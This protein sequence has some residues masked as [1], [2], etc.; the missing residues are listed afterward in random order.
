MKPLI[1]T[2][3]LFVSTYLH[4]QTIITES[5]EVTCSVDSIARP[6]YVPASQLALRSARRSYFEFIFTDSVPEEAKPAIKFAGR[7]WGSYLISDIPIRVEVRWFTFEGRNSLGSARPIGYIRSDSLATKTDVL[8]PLALGESLLN[9]NLNGEQADIIISINK[10]HNFYFGTDGKVPEEHYDLT[11][12]ILHEIGHGVGFTASSRI[13]EEGVGRFSK[14][15]RI[16]DTFLIARN[17]TSLTD[18]FL[19]K[20][21]SVELAAQ[22][23]SQQVYFNHPFV[24]RANGGSYVWI[25]APADFRSGS[26]ISH[27]MRSQRNTRWS[28][29]TLM[30]PSTAKQEVIH[31]PDPVALAMLSAM[32]WRVNFHGTVTSTIEIAQQEV[33]LFPNPAIDQ[34]QIRWPEELPM[35]VQYQITDIS[36]R[37][38]QTGQIAQNQRLPLNNFSTGHYHLKLQDDQFLYYGKFVVNRK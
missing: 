9:R 20:N 16:Y 37:V 38:V 32:G 24:R 13:N 23:T 25:Y 36:G 34:L 2:L 26:S 5:V 10:K 7:I 21:P 35:Q 27:L 11:S 29:K 14:P 31:R 12:L 4:A 19:Y 22:L 33:L 30:D 1:L 3:L 17:G 18:T 6:S 8:Y 15:A 28:Q